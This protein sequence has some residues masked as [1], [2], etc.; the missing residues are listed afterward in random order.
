MMKFKVL[1]KG[2]N[3]Y[4]SVNQTDER[5]FDRN[6]DYDYSNVRMIIAR[7]EENEK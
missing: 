7:V 1:G 5:C 3:F 4:F 2:G 6:I